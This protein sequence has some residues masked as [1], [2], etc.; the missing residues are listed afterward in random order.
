MMIL[1]RQSIK[2]LYFAVIIISLLSC[3]FQK[4]L[5][6]NNCTTDKIYLEWLQEAGIATKGIKKSDVR[7]TINVVRDT[8][9]LKQEYSDE[10]YFEG[11][12]LGRNKVGLWKGFYKGKVIIETAYLGET[13]NRPMFVSLWNINGELIRVTKFNTI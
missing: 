2:L 4:K 11:R 13:N 6:T 12:I 8:S 3:Q 7:C 10:I 9:Y 1:R 5:T